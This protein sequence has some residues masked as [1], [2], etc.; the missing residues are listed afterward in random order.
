[1]SLLLV[2]ALITALD[3]WWLYRRW[4][5]GK[6]WVEW[7]IVLVGAIL[8]AGPLVNMNPQV[9]P[10]GREF[11]SNIHYFHFWHWLSTCGL[12]AFWMP[13]GGGSPI[14]ADPFPP[15][16][17]PLVALPV[18][19]FG[20]VNGAK[21]AVFLSFLSAGLAQWWLGYQW[22]L[23]PVARLWGAWMLMASGYISGRFSLG[24]MHMVV[25]LGTAA[26][27]FPAAWW[28]WNHR[29]RKGY[30]PLAVALGM[31]LLA[32]RGYEIT[33]LGFSGGLLLAGRALTGRKWPAEFWQRLGHA[34]LGML[35]LAAPTLLPW[36][37]TLGAAAKDIDPEFKTSQSLGKLL[38]NFVA[39]D[40][41]F[42]RS[43]VLDKVPYPE[44]TAFF[45]DWLPLLLAVVAVVVAWLKAE[46]QKRHLPVGWWTMWALLILWLATGQPFRWLVHWFPQPALR[47]LLGG[48]RHIQQT[49]ALAIPLILA[50]ASA[51]VDEILARAADWKITLA[52]HEVRVALPASLL[53]IGALFIPWRNAW[54]VNQDWFATVDYPKLDAGL[55]F[56]AQA[57]L[58][59][60]DA[61]Y[62]EHYWIEP[63]F[64]RDLK[65]LGHGAGA[66]VRWHWKDWQAP[67]PARMLTRHQ[68]EVLDPQRDTVVQ[69]DEGLFGVIHP[70]DYAYVQTEGGAHIPCNA[71]G[72]GGILILT[73]TTPEDGDLQVMEKAWP[74]WWMR[75]DEGAWQ[76]VARQ[77]PYIG[78]P[79]PA[80]EHTIHL[81]YIPEE[82]LL[83]LLLLFVWLGWHVYAG[84]RRSSAA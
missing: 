53:V 75:V 43:P 9:I 69:V 41:E 64:A 18:L 1:M 45:I 46:K 59:W 8:V 19:L 38:V 50:L 32:E 5:W 35:A 52:S 27:V 58:N 79:L 2:L 16:L 81:R 12:C 29:G 71:A 82:V 78:G 11:L 44:L 80:G 7:T 39:A 65:V 49:A 25:G 56:L 13:F 83:G 73:C 72:W 26:W 62:G 4:P 17:H 36:M 54:L 37:R 66:V 74:G 28:L 24:G 77:R 68:D 70:T 84:L 31:L 33:A 42:Y 51:A 14:L 47:D 34:V 61:P 3:A 48:L 21:V 67:S 23:H 60:V 15:L 6:L 10:A 40:P 22:R 76:R 55:D 20:V 57:G 63:A 30:L